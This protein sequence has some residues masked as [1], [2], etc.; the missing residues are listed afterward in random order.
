MAGYNAY[1]RLT[2]QAHGALVA[3]EKS[4]KKLIQ[5]WL[6]QVYTLDIVMGLE[7]PFD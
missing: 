4:A 3:T 2:N 7:Y 6:F 5:I 1:M